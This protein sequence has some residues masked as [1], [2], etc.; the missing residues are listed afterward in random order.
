MLIPHSINTLSNFIS[1][2]YTD[3]LDICDK[4]IDYHKNSDNKVL[5]ET[6]TGVDKQAKDS[7]DVLMGPDMFDQYFN[8]LLKPAMI[9]YIEDYPA[10]ARYANFG[11]KE[12]AQIQHYLPGGAFH[13]W[14]CE[15]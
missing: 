6:A 8:R 10:V 2:Y 3:D 9:G 11:V 12:P 4:I 7:S 1:A 14:H 13:A 5:G 15:R